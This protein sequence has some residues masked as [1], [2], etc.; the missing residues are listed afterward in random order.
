MAQPRTGLHAQHHREHRRHCSIC[1]LLLGA[2]V[3]VLVVL[4][5][6]D[7]IRLLLFHFSSQPVQEKAAWWGTVDGRSV[8]A[9]CLAGRFRAAPF[10]LSES[11]WC[12]AILVALL[13]N[14][15]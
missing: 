12:T 6:C 9:C 13:Q 3:V 14:R 1:C 10:R 5:G 7:G 4:P 11:K 15:F 2:V 8:V